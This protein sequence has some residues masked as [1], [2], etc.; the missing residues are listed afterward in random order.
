MYPIAIKSLSAFNT[1]LI[2]VLAEMYHT[3][4]RTQK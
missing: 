3:P 4:H 2:L 1:K